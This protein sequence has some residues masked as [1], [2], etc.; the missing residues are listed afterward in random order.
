M[1]WHAK[2]RDDYFARC[3]NELRIPAEHANYADLTQ[4]DASIGLKLGASE[5]RVA[6]LGRNPHEMM[7]V[8]VGL[9]PPPTDPTIVYA[10]RTV[11]ITQILVDIALSAWGL[12]LRRNV[13]TREINAVLWD[14]PGAIDAVMLQA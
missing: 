1:A 13:S 14:E 3:A 9:T 8:F 2:T 5:K 10:F 6:C 11:L 12:T 4:N 7:N